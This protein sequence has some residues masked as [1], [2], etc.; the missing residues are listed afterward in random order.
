MSNVRIAWKDP[1]NVRQGIAHIDVQASVDG[2]VTPSSIAQVAPG[3][4]FLVDQDVQP[5]TWTYDLY[6]VAAD[7][8]RSAKVTGS[9]AVPFQPPGAVT[10]LT[11]NIE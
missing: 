7:G 4:Q 3:V 1:A 8:Q 6:V 9:I 5:G 11:L 10:T 2:G